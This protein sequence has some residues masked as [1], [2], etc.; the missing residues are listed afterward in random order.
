[1]PRVSV[2]MTSYNHERFVAEAV[3]SVLDQTFQD[4]EFIIIDDGSR[5]GTPQV[6]RSFADPRVS[7]TAFA[8]NRGACTAM[9]HCVRMAQGELVAVIN[10]DDAWEPERLARQ[11]AFLDAHPEIGA[12]FSYVTA[13]DEEGRPYEA[14]THYYTQLFDQP[15]RSRHEWLRHFFFWDNCLCHP[16]LLIRRECY[17]ALGLYDERLAQL[18]DMDFWIRLCG[19]YSIH[20][21]PERLVRFRILSGNANTSSQGRQDA[22]IRHNIELAQVLSHY[23]HEPLLGQVAEI[24]PEAAEQ[25]GRLERDLLPFVV[26]T[27]AA[28]TEAP[29]RHGFAL[30]L[31]YPLLGDPA[32]ARRVEERLGFSYRDLI[33]LAGKID[34]YGVLQIATLRSQG[35]ELHAL[36]GQLAATGAEQAR[37]QADLAEQ[38]RRAEQARADL[39]TQVER[40][41]AY[42]AHLADATRLNQLLDAE[43][44]SRKRA[45]ERDHEE[46]ARLHAEYASAVAARNQQQRLLTQERA[47]LRRELRAAQGRIARIEGLL[48]VRAARKARRMLRGA[49]PP[50]SGPIIEGY[51]DVPRPDSVLSGALEVYGWALSHAGAIVAVQA[52]LD[53]APLGEV[54]YG[55]PRPDVAALKQEPDLAECGFLGRFVIDTLNLARSAHMVTVRLVDSQG[56]QRDLSCR[57]QIGEDAYGAW[58]SRHTLDAAALAAQREEAALLRERPLVSVLVPVYNTPEPVLRAMVESVL[59][60]TY[61]RWE[62]ILVDGASPRAEVR[63]TLRE[64][65]TR[66]ER[67][68]LRLLDANAGIA[69]NTNAALEAARGEFIALLDH[70]DLLAPEALFENVA[71]LNAHPDT[72]AIYSDQDKVDE[73]GRRFEPFFKPD[74][75]PELFRGVMYVGHLLCVRRSTA[76]AAGGFLAEFDGV[77][78]YEFMLRVAETT[79]RIRH[80]PKILYHW[81]TLTGSIASRSDAKSNIDALQV[82]AVEAHLRRIGARAKA[83]AGATPH[84]V[85]VTPTGDPQP[86]VSIVIPTRDAPEMLGRCLHSIYEQSSYKNFEVVLVDNESENCEAIA[87]TRRYPVRRV[88]LNSPFNYSRANN[89]GVRHAAGECLLFLNNDTEVLARDWLEQL[90][91]Y[92][93]QPDVGAAGGLLLYPDRTVQHAGIVLGLRGTADH[94]M[95]G[96]PHD[97]DGYA[98]SLACA[99]EVSAVTGACLM[100]RRALYEQVGG[101]NEHFFTHYQDVDLCL[102]LRAL[103][104]RNLY[105]PG[106]TLV[107]YESVTRKAYYDL[108]DRNLL[109]DLWQETIDRGDSYYNPNFDQR[110]YNYTVRLD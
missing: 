80:I 89:L 33:A 20:I 24:F 10:S 107:H 12:V 9:N 53:G 22:H 77:Q 52:L 102:K 45:G 25:A 74:W 37:L 38:T 41:E 27:Q 29:A 84:R 54:F 49:T 110:S 30:S 73:M 11:V 88:Y 13:V 83:V 50:P 14:G 7:F 57:V 44:S 100:V 17:Q 69:G 59:A 6:L 95:R 70:D 62:L 86:R 55:H 16:S 72:D 40:A 58:A 34:V 18:P 79:D 98:G 48:P 75:S 92:A 109:L 28:R 19:R 39:A 104:L 64:L 32:R 78:D 46:L 3:Q 97:S 21:L 1:M 108:V 60:Q 67:I 76:L 85:R 26:A 42:K 51:L 90:V 66:D 65:A 5:D 47:L 36:R 106:A 56:N 81:R 94:V 82:R 2:L 61:D 96:F 63:T 71:L 31:L 87:L 68:V 93:C 35:E 91:Y 99:R 43:L 8:E 15:N 23:V 103:G 101:F 105:V 4:F